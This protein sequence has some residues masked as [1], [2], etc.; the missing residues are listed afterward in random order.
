MAGLFFFSRDRIPLGDPWHK[1]FI[2]LLCWLYKRAV[3]RPPVRELG[4]GG[5]KAQSKVG[6]FQLLAELPGA[7]DLDPEHLGAF[8]K[9]L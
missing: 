4:R 6:L 8:N 7:G 1:G 3:E 2:P 9:N 5:S